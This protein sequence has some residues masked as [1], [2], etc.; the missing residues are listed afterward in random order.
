[1]VLA[2]VGQLWAGVGP[3][4]PTELIINMLKIRPVFGLRMPISMAKWG[5]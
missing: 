4:Q 2:L 5:F 3:N 1:M